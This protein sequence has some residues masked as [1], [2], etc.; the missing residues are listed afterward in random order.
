MPHPPPPPPGL[1][2]DAFGLEAPPSRVL[3][4][5]AHYDDESL[6]CGGTL[7]ALAQAGCTLHLAV[8]TDV[9]HTNAPTPFVPRSSEWE[10]QRQARRLAAFGAVCR[11]LGATATHLGQENLSEHSPPVGPRAARI[12]TGAR[13]GL[14]PLLAE[15]RPDVVMTHGRHGEYGHGQHLLTHRLV[16][17][18]WHGPLATFALPAPPPA[19]QRWHAVTVDGERKS[20]LLA[21][22]RE[23]TTQEGTWDPR[24]IP[25]YAPWC[26]DTEYFV[27]HEEPALEARPP[28]HDVAAPVMLYC[29]SSLGVGH[30]QRCMALAAAISRERRAI[31]LS[32]GLRTPLAGSAYHGIDLVELPAI[33]HDSEGKTLHAGAGSPGLDAAWSERRRIIAET[34]KAAA[35]DALVLDYYPF[36][37]RDFQNEIRGLME[38][39]RVTAWPRRP[40][41]VCSLRDIVEPRVEMAE[42]YAG[43]AV[44]ELDRSFHHLLVHCDEVFLH[45]EDSFR[46]P[47]PVR[48][49]VHYT[50]F[51]LPPLPRPA[52]ETSRSGPVLVTAGGG[53]V[54]MS[55]LRAA[56][57]AAREHGLARE[58]GMRIVTGLHLPQDE[59]DELERQARAVEGLSLERWIDDVPAV[60][61]RARASVSQAGYNTVAELL[62]ARVPSVLVPVGHG[63]ATDQAVRSQ[64]LESL[65]LAQVLDP[66]RLS[67]DRLAGAVRK[68]TAQRPAPTEFTFDGA[69]RSAALL[70]RFL[71]Q[72]KSG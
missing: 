55:L 38:A 28:R 19:G 44:R 60:L 30:F 14:A 23:Q 50:G 25:A 29:Q 3:V 41:M 20:R 49:P 27:A 6:F 45:L 36:G 68:A 35:P 65:G 47:A 63:T 70:E 22:Y 1:P 71:A 53:R 5:V 72:V 54:G 40:L 69:N 12:E 4:V 33:V 17:D 56:L 10:E 7:L 42:F 59:W 11:E 32:G 9:R 21:F 13:R 8:V 61:A 43:L 66:A 24:Q 18:C 37:K 48:I 26:G 39:V 15:F 57:E 34:V 67:G 64:R 62:H 31:V 58:W 46:P 16:R 52:P 2:W 51:V